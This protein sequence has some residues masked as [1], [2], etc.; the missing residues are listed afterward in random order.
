M[1]KQE[2]VVPRNF[3]LIDELE[4]GIRG[5]GD[6]T[7]SWGLVDD[8]R[9]LTHWNATII[10]PLKTNFENRIYNLSIECGPLYPDERP[11]VNFLTKINLS[12]VHDHG[13][14]QMPYLKQ[15]KR[16]CSM[17]GLLQEIRKCMASKENK[18]ASQPPENTFYNN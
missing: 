2:V 4:E 13:V 14:V 9:T 17:K 6:A 8:D 18:N 16:S 10:G 3:I 15:W 7:I 12:I 5:G 11:Q 1:A